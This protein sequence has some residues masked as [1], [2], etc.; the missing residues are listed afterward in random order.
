MSSILQILRSSHQHSP[1]AIANLLNIAV[2]EYNKLEAGTAGLTPEQ[3]FTLSE[4]YKVDV[5]DLMPAGDVNN[6]AGAY[7]RGIFN[8]TNYYEKVVFMTQPER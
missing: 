6:N 2:S 1:V 3:A 4:F 8:V 5:R 7:S